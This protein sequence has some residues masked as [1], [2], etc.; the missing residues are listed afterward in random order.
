[1]VSDGG[2]P[3][4]YEGEWVD[5]KMCGSGKFVT[6]DNGPTYTG[7]FKD[8]RKHGSGREQWGNQL[9][10]DYCCGM[11]FKHKSRFC[12]YEGSL[13]NDQFDGKGYFVCI[14]RS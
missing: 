2:S 5:D 11:G 8:N 7:Q 1:M 6:A 13:R 9:G 14:G 10:I 12:R 3:G 4:M